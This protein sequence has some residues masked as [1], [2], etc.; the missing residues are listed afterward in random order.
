M[1]VNR[2]E[3]LQTG[4]AASVLMATGGI[5][6]AAVDDQARL[7]MVIVDER[8]P[9][10]VAF[11]RSREHRGS[12]VRMLERDRRGDITSLWYHDLYYRWEQGPMAMAGLTT[13]GSLFCLQL[14]AQ[15]KGMRLVAREEQADGLVRW[16][17]AP[18][19]TNS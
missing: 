3:F 5:A 8:F 14:L 1:G 4:M 12:P 10:S 15:D 19:R 9:E 6:S 16:A 2:R 13:A 17:I 18:R 7:S 11:G